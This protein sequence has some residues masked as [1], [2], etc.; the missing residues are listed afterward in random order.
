MFIRAKTFFIVNLIAIFSLAIG[1][2]WLMAV[3]TQ[4]APTAD[5]IIVTTTADG[6]QED[7]QCSLREALHNANTNTQFSDMAGECPAGSASE[8]DVIILT[9][10]AEYILTVAGT[11]NDEGDLDVLDDVRF[12]VDG[13]FPAT[14]RMDVVGQRVMEIHG[15]NV[16]IENI[17]LRGGNTGGDGGGILNNGGSLT[18]TNVF[19][20][21]NIAQVGGGLYNLN[22]T[23]VISN[24]QIILNNG[25]LG[26]GGIF[27]S[28]AEANLTVHGSMIRVNESSVGSGGGISNS[29]GTVLIEAD[30]AVNL[31]TAQING[32]GLLNSNGGQ[33]TIQHTTVQGNTVTQGA[34]GG[35]LVQDEDSLLQVEKSFI[36]DNRALHNNEGRGGGIA[37]LNGATVVSNSSD[38][39]GNQAFAGGGLFIQEAILQ[40]TESSLRENTAIV[41]GGGLVNLDSQATLQTALIN[42]NEAAEDGG[43]IYNNGHLTM[44]SVVISEN[45]SDGAGGGLFNAGGVAHL[46]SVTFQKNEA[47]AGGGILSFDGEILLDK[48]TLSGN[49]ATQQ[50]GGG[51]LSHS[52][53]L[54]LQ[55]QTAINNNHA[56]VAGG[57]MFLLAGGQV[58]LDDVQL[59]G[60]ETDGQGAGIAA[61]S[62]SSLLAHKTAFSNNKSV[63]EGG[64]I[65]ITSGAQFTLTVGTF[66]GNEA[67]DG[68]GI[69][70][71]EASG[72]VTFN[73]AALVYNVASGQGGGV[74][75]AGPVKL[76][77]ST[78]SNNTAVTAGGLYLAN[79][80]DVDARHITVAENR[81]AL[82]DLLKEEEATLELRSSIIA[83]DGSDNCFIVGSNIVSLGH[84][85]AN[86]NTCGGLTEVSDQVETDPLLGPL[87]NHGGWS[88]SHS[89]LL[90]SPAI[91]AADVALCAAAPMNG[92]DQRGLARDTVAC[93]SG[94]HESGLTL[95]VSLAGDGLGN[96]AGNNIDCPEVNCTAKF[97]HGEEVALTALPTAPALFL[98]WSGSIVSQANP[99]VVTMDSTQQLTATF[100]TPPPNSFLLAVSKAGAGS[101]TV[102]SNPA[103]I[104][105]GQ[106]CA[107]FFGEGSMVSLTATPTAGS[108]FTGWTGAIT[109]QNKTVQLTMDEAKN[110]TATFAEGEAPEAEYRLYLPIVTRP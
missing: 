89:L 33:I 71:A 101:G 14:I 52:S 51:I 36:T 7:N 44:N 99:L 4:A 82:F 31:N 21:N 40:F 24:S 35:M 95:A 70:V 18:L 39:S 75:T 91:G 98:G 32:G 13:D 68:A 86:D 74:W 61:G 54:T 105:C 64:G 27:N 55:N 93:D 65:Y 66:A 16:E 77:N 104:N 59:H 73:Q 43:G 85:I 9:S 83:T 46:Y 69:Y 58:T 41:G 106:T 1:T 78:V 12:V 38:V 28:G 53:Q 102:T 8:T 37:V 17:T 90:G 62:H 3:P 22:G 94:A 72:Q 11:G 76:F 60:N 19:L 63:A 50:M 29:E 48:S 10:G 100:G 87:A 20:Q 107:A 108:Q 81:P 15:V 2:A 84:N 26:G 45:L 56:V 30:S 23:A 79:G 109:S 25:A 103:G 57:G 42:A 80:A 49:L 5:P 34:G 97:T 6:L 67:T 96:V 88:E 92:V 110:V 47:K